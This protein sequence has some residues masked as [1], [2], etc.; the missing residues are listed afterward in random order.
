MADETI[1]T[2]WELLW[3]YDPNGLVVARASD[4]IISIVNPA[5]CQMFAVEADY[6]I[7][8]S[9]DDVLGNADD[10]RHVLDKQEVIHGKHVHYPHRNLHVSKHIFP[11][12]EHASV[13]A[14]FV[15][16][17]TEL[18]RARLLQ[19]LKQETLRNVSEVVDKH[20]KA[21]QEIASLLGETTAETKVTLL[22]LIEAMKDDRID[23]A[24]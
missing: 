19:R 20:M 2:V 8:R 12:H 14:I 3:D 6:A 1:K 23:D 24:D 16:V 22:K 7:G 5:F 9:L 11:I 4:L 17:T 13:A 15:D 18:D 10:F 21:A